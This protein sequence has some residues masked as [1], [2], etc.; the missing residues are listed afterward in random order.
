MSD[1]EH[2]YSLVRR[3]RG[4]PA[5]VSGV[6]PYRNDGSLA[7][8]PDEA[9]AAVLSTLGRRLEAEG[10]RL[11]DVAKVTVFLTDIAWLPT[12]NEVWCQAFSDPRPAR[13]TVQV[14]ALP[15]GARIEVE[16]IL[17]VPAP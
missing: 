7:E 1:V 14:S 15:R 13:S 17:D 12:L 2:P 6:L 3:T 11:A 16:A 9:I 5:Y 10:L 8:E 4:A